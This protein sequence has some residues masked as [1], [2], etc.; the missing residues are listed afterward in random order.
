MVTEDPSDA[1]VDLLD[2][3]DAGLE[4]GQHRHVTGQNAETA[5]LRWHVH[6]TNVAVAVEHLNTAARTQPE[7][8]VAHTNEHPFCFDSK[9]QI[10]N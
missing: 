4:R 3:D 2:S 5:A 1:S 7:T 8:L 10:R 9:L 6:L